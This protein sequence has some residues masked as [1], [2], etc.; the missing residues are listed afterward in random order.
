MQGRGEREREST[1]DRDTAQRGECEDVG[2]VEKDS[3]RIWKNGRKK[4]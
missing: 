3:N 4:G 2:V 1:R